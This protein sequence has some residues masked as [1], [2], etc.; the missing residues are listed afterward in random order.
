MALYRSP[1]LIDQNGNITAAF[2]TYTLFCPI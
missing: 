1:E 2:A